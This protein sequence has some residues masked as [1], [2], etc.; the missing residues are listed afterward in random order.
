MMCRTVKNIIFNN[1]ITFGN[2]VQFVEIYFR[3]LETYVT[4]YNGESG[5]VLI[6]PETIKNLAH[7][8]LF[9][10]PDVIEIDVFQVD[11]IGGKSL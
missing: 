5:E 6:F 4:V 2:L 9:D 1:I 3:K 10:A 8:L 7:L 11:V